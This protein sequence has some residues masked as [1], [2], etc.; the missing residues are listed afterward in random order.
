[1]YDYTPVAG[2]VGIAGNYLSLLWHAF[3]IGR[4]LKTEKAPY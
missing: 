1:M 3:W 4:T 2:I